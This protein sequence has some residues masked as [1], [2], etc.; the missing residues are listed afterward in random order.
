[1]LEYSVLV[2][3]EVAVMMDAKDEEEAKS[4]A[5]QI[6]RGALAGNLMSLAVLACDELGPPSYLTT[7]PPSKVRD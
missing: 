3:I 4:R 7:V 1:M 5:L 2:R 6:C